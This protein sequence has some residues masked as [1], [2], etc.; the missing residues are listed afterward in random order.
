MKNDFEIARTG[1]T[2]C[3]LFRTALTFKKDAVHPNK[4]KS[5]NLI[6]FI[7]RQSIFGFSFKV[8]LKI[9]RLQYLGNSGVSN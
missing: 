7:L 2:L 6:H 9:I 5:Q 8:G 3:D 4:S 1:K